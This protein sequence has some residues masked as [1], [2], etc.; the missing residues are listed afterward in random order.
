ME[1]RSG[2]TSGAILIIFAATLA[3]CASGLQGSTRPQH[4][5]VVVCYMSSW[6]TYRPDKGHF[7]FNELHAEHCTH[8]VYAFAG[9]NAST[10]TIRSIDPWADL[11]EGGAKG[12]YKRATGLRSRH[13]G[14][15]VTLAI[16]G[17]NEGSANYSEL[18]ASPERRRTFVNSAL[19]FIR[20]HG[21]DGLDLDWEFPA[22]RGGAPYDR[23]NFV[24]L[25]RDLS[26]AFKSKGLLLTA[27]IGAGIE[28]INAAYD[29]PQLSQY[30]DLIHVMAYDYHGAWDQK[31]LANAP[32]HSATDKLTVEDSVR[33]LLK[34]GAPPGKLVL[35]LPMYGR[36]FVLASTPGSQ[37]GSPIGAV[38]LSKGFRGPYTNEDGFMGYNEICNELVN[39]TLGW[40]RGWDEASATP[41]AIRE[42]KVITY[43]DPRSMMMKAD[44]AGE[45][46][47]AGVMV[48]SVDTDDFLG[49]CAE[50][51]DGFLDPL[52]G[53]DYPI[54]RSINLAL[55][56][57]P[58]NDEDNHLPANDVVAE[59]AAG[60]TG[61][62][63]FLVI[64][65]VFTIF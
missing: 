37:S 39:K 44:F 23:E 32:L 62:C 24:S 9:L 16:G 63:S 60:I 27:A 38:A 26:N 54:M 14:L 42:D 17:W 64:S 3:H 43:D 29:V 7:G 50:V 8:L 4:D 65:I 41:W 57:T 49:N 1:N 51:H 55:A 53:S 20:K 46:H 45:M 31:V 30:L 5:K 58:S 33:Y 56:R 48:W 6:A 21:F 13:P 19:A 15:K 34:L 40:R 10:S 36:T 11:E 25:V 61:L 28:T 18:A 47:L 12:G 52:M 22:Q 35:G 2:F 59:S